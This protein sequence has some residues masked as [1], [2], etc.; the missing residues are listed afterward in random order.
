MKSILKEPR[1]MMVDQKIFIDDCK[2]IEFGNPSSHTYGGT[3]MFVTTALYFIQHFSVRYNV[4]SNLMMKAGAV[5]FFIACNF[6]LGF[7]RVFKG[8]HTY[9]QVV[10]GFV[11]GLLLA[12]IQMN[13]F[14]EFH[15]YFFASIKRRS[16][17][18]LI[19]NRYTI[20]FGLLLLGAIMVHLNTNSTFATPEVW[21]NNII[22]NCGDKVNKDL[23]NPE[24][25]NFE[26][27]LFSLGLLGS[28]ISMIVEQKTSIGTYVSLNETATQNTAKRAVV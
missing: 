28:Y 18:Q 27:V 4:R 7:S 11:Q 19:F 12:A 13:V 9:N 26:K 3:F 17:F 14:Y 16:A 21:K 24:T 8:V 23:I 22:R 15:F 5:T 25:A 2:H 6:L 10:S 20:S 1:P